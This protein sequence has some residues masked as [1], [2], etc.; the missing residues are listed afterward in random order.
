MIG[1]G[2]SMARSCSVPLPSGRR[3]MPISIPEA[4]SLVV[5]ARAGLM[6]ID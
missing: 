4:K 2:L 3:A 5:A 1:S 6:V